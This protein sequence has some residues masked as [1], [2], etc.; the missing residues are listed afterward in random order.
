MLT[1]VY[2]DN[3][4]CFSNF[5]LQLNPRQLIFG[6]NGTG[7]SSL[8]LAL[9]FLKNL[10][11]LGNPLELQFPA[12]SVTKSSTS[13]L[14]TFEIEC[15]V[16]GENI[17]YRLEIEQGQYPAKPLVKRETLSAEGKLAF[18]FSASDVRIFGPADTPVSAYKFDPARSALQNV[19]AVGSGGQALSRF[20]GWLRSIQFFQIQPSQIQALSDREDRFPSGNLSNFPSWYRYLALADREADTAFLE[21][22]RHLLDGFKYLDFAS[23]GEQKLLRAYFS[24][25][26][27]DSDWFS[28]GELSDGQRCLIGLYA[29]LHFALKKGQTV[30]IDEPDNFVSL[31]EIQPW[32]F[33]VE[34]SVDSGTGQ[35]L[36]ISHHPEIINQWA[37]DSGIRFYRDKTGPVRTQTFQ[38]AEN[39]GLSPAELIAR[40]WEG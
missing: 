34:D 22:L 11:V 7:K 32:L 35:A 21:D 33:S 20:G 14:Q 13:N 17:L 23:V 10:L 37:V 12:R 40:G 4:L 36:I 3:Y 28:L 15:V 5:E 2:I 16:D 29:I 6:A 30:C 18:E 31:R 26:G 1:R 8:F 9:L 19:L 27:Q 24:K 39:Q 25:G 38:R